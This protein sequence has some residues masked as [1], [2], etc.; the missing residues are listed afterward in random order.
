MYS[1]RTVNYLIKKELDLVKLAKRIAL[2]TL[3]Q[4]Y[5][6]STNLKY[7]EAIQSV[8]NEWEVKECK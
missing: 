6:K 2:K 1:I 5:N 4:E 3:M 7:K 8:I